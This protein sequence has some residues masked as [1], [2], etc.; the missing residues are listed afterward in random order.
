MKSSQE[1]GCEYEK[2]SRRLDAE[3]RGEFEGVVFA[4]VGMYYKFTL[5]VA[6]MLSCKVED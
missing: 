1:A 4:P 2:V 6:Q 5:F 3:S